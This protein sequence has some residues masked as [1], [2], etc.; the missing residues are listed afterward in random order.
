MPGELTP[1][2]VLDLGFGGYGIVRS[3]VRYGIPVIGFCNQK[4]LPEYRTKLC[5]QKVYFKG[6]SDLRDKL[7]QTVSGLGCKP[8]LFIT[9]DA[10]VNFIIENRQFI[11]EHFLIH[12]PT[13]AVL[14]LLLDKTEFT[15]YARDNNI[16]IPKTHNLFNPED[17]ESIAE[18]LSFPVIL[19][20]FNRTDNWRK[21]NLSKAYCLQTID[22][23]KK[24]YREIN[25]VESRLMVQ[26]W[27]PGG[28]SNV[29]YCL[30]YFNDQSECLASFTG[31]KI[32]QC[33]VGT[34]TG[35]STTAVDNPYVFDRT[36]EILQQ[37]K[38]CGFGSVEFKLHD[39]NGRY[40][41]IEPTV[42][43][44][45]QIGY[46]ATVNG[47]N[48]SLR[49]YNALTRS[50]IEESLPPVKKVIYIEEPTEIASAFVHLR[51]RMI[52]VREYFNSLKGPKAYRYYNKG[53]LRVFRGLFMKAV[54]FIF[55]KQ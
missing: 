37:L 8:V 43:R 20:P 15:T 49:C 33:P 3:L 41:L 27:I 22:E 29:Y 19:K 6:E 9:T 5:D 47:M 7:E 12:L 25:P 34:G 1:A 38:Y 10:Y 2:V 40:Y 39:S 23:L 51:R 21:A 14:K 13:N 18:S 48:L 30:V 36:L 54:M 17:L 32:R 42:G 28:D 44:V 31:Y 35:C 45:E 53:D 26:E 24:L 52:T 16:L 55:K 11:D 50:E 4:K 46:V